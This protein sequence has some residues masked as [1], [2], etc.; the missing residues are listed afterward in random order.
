MYT[1]SGTGIYS[2]RDSLEGGRGQLEELGV[3]TWSETLAVVGG[4]E[5]GS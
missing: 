4:R 2:C 5:G 1:W 3:Y